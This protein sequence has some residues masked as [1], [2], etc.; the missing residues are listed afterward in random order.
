MLFALRRNSS[1]CVVFWITP[2]STSTSVAGACCSDLG[3]QHYG[4]ADETEF[5]ENYKTHVASTVIMMQVWPPVGVGPCC[6]HYARKHALQPC[7]LSALHLAFYTVR[8]M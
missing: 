2:N 3:V 4:M 6:M 7:C 1:S 5:L 8:R